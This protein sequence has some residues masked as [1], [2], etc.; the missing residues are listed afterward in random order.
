MST[1]A[2]YC[3]DRSEQTTGTYNTGSSPFNYAAYGRLETNKTPSYN[4]ININDAFSS[5]IAGGVNG[6]LTYPVGL[7]TADEIAYAGGIHG[8]YNANAWYIR[9]S[10]NASK[11]IENRYYND[12]S[13]EVTPYYSTGTMWC[14]LL[15]LSLWDG[16]RG[17]S[18]S[19][20]VSTSHYPGYLAMSNL[21][22]LNG[23][24]P[25]VSLKSCIKYSTGNGAPETPYEIVGNGGC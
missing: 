16:S 12:P 4:C 24:R 23:V 6:K 14:W 15:S 19:F 7:M 1:D 11:V 18:R 2:V 21:Y 8:T 5:S 25:V 9:N 22:A 3:N 17:Y 10:N 20:G 13:T